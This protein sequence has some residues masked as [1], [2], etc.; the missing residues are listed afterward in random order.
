MY[1]LFSNTTDLKRALVH[2]PGLEIERLIPWGIEHP[3]SFDVE[4]TRLTSVMVEEHKRL[5]ETLKKEIGANNVFELGD[6]LTDIFELYDSQKRKEILNYALGESVFSMYE[7]HLKRNNLDINF[8]APQDISMDLIVGYPRIWESNS[9]GEIEIPIIQ[10]KD[11]L[12]HTRDSTF[13]LPSGLAIGAI[14]RLRRKGD[15]GLIR[16]IFKYHPQLSTDNCIDFETEVKILSSNY[17]WMSTASLGIEG[18]NFQVLSEDTIVMGVSYSW[19]GANY[20]AQRFAIEKT[21]EL[22]FLKDPYKRIQRIYVVH[23]PTVQHFWHLD[24]VFNMI[25]PKSA[26]VMPYIFGYPLPIKQVI[27][28][29]VKKIATDL[30]LTSDYPKEYPFYLPDV[31]SF[32][33]AG[34]T[35]TYTRTE[36]DEHQKAIPIRQ[37]GKF[38]LDV[39]M[40]DGFLDYDR[41]VWAGG[42]PRDFP[43]PYE[44]ARVA[45]REQASQACNVFVIRPNWVL[46][47]DHNPY[48]LTHLE[49]YLQERQGHLEKIR[50]AE[51]AKSEGGPHC[52]IADLDRAS[53]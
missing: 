49:K 36:F 27:Y 5:V 31:S 22:I 10:P 16:T 18:G 30:I 26:I 14:N 6:L 42:D 19:S 17:N 7:D 3:F 52:L 29:L 40:D 12:R 53:E 50:G 9:K 8:R 1:E 24:S 44:H 32:D 23:I 39:L 25:G 48:T 45:L 38:F 51:Q 43:N 46:A 13:A 47:F 33:H 20:N 34:L 37:Q 41:I 15:A 35:E 2:T 4:Y 11:G 21:I 28:P